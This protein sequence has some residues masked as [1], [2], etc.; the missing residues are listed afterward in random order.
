MEIRDFLDQMLPESWKNEF[1]ILF[2]LRGS[3][4]PEEDLSLISDCAVQ[5]KIL[6]MH[7]P[8]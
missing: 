5:S 3:F 8:F 7:L 4:G 2:S 6:G 1:Y